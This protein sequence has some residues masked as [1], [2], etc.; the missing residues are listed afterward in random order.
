MAPPNWL[1]HVPFARWI[2]RA[3]RPNVLVELGTHTGN[4]YSAFAQAV[5][6]LGLPTA[7]Y[8]VDTWKGD[9]QSGHYDEEVFVEWSTFHAAHFAAFSQLIR[10]TF[11]EARQHFR[12]GTIDLLH[13]DGLH[14]AEALRHDL[15]SWLPKLSDRAVVLI[16]DVNE[17][18]DDFGAWRVWEEIQ[19]RFPSFTFLHG[20]GLGVLA[21]GREPAADVQ[22]LTVEASR[23]AVAVAE[24]RQCFERLGGLIQASFKATTARDLRDQLASRDAHIQTFGAKAA[25]LAGRL[26]QARSGTGGEGRTRAGRSLPEA[27]SELEAEVAAATGRMREQEETKQRLALALDR[28]ANEQR[29]TKQM[30]HKAAENA[31]QIEL[32][33]KTVRHTLTAASVDRHQRDEL[34]QKL[35]SVLSSRI[36]RWGALFRAF[37]DLLARARLLTHPQG[38]LLA[39]RC[40]GDP[41]TLRAYRLLKSS[42]L[43]DAAYYRATNADVA[44]ADVDPLLHFVVFGVREGR[45]PHALFDSRYYASARGSLPAGTNPLLDF[46]SDGWRAN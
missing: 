40:F 33:E 17:R 32:L 16:H 6:Q 23:D 31:R 11:D 41:V 20:H 22:W 37:S 19:D 27:V 24:I 3:I 29:H 30:H 21:V 14:T 5:Q 46:L 39:L 35:S 12:D 8:A 18:R 1:S 28:L 2:V 34:G 45:S 42:P 36:W 38:A 4:S 15:T 10:S 7:C 26:A 25:A 43:F 9:S 44:A 13:I